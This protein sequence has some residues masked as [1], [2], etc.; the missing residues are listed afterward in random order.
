MV[1]RLVFDTVQEWLER[2][3]KSWFRYCNRRY[4]LARWVV[5]VMMGVRGNMDV[6][7]VMVRPRRILTACTI[8]R[9]LQGRRIFRRSRIDMMMVARTLLARERK[10]EKNETYAPR[11]GW[12]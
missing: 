10:G 5:V 11:V 8:L 2:K 4:S 12:M 1:A 6:V 9:W 7:M 3:L